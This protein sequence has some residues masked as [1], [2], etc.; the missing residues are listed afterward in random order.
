MQR[1]CLVLWSSR[2]LHRQHILFR[3]FVSKLFRPFGAIFAVRHLPIGVKTLVLSN[4]LILQLV[5]N[6][7]DPQKG[8]PRIAYK[9]EN[10]KTLLV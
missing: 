4:L 10:R 2:Y 7:S 5:L 3:L 9:G 1:F 8:I 6:S